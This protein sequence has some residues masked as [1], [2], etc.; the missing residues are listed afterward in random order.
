MK[1]S[2]KDRI[3]GSFAGLAVGDAMGMPFHE[4]ITD[5]IKT[6]CGGLAKTFFPILKE[7]FIHLDFKL[8]Q[9]TDDTTLT[10]V[11]AMAI[12]KYKG[13]VS[14]EH[15]VQEL[16]HWVKNN[17]SIWQL[18]NVY[19]P[20]TKAAFNHLDNNEFNTYEKRTRSWCYLGTSN[21]S[22]MRVS[23]AGWA[24]PGEW[25]KAVE[26]ACNIILPTHPTDVALS[27]AG[28]Q[29]AA[30]S[31]ALTQSA[32]VNSIIDAALTGASLGEKIGKKLARETS[33]RYPVPN[34]EIA[35]DLA[36]KAKDPYEAGRLIRRSIGSHFHASETLAT[37]IGIFYAAK[38]NPEAAIIA[39]VNNGGD[40]DTIA[41][42]VGALTGA[43]QGISAIPR[44]WVSTIETVNHLECEKLAVE[45]CSMVDDRE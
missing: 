10:V 20:S 21:G 36:E 33:Q 8:G 27:A 26:L 35:L 14:T 29:A 25:K 3:W 34:L 19:G 11:T 32:T 12:L 17:K 28:G 24:Y 1:I 18:G 31:Q 30:I 38:G 2:L 16:A 42:I 40:T 9:V 45:F 13:L 5:E 7:E 23:P 39:A 37:A 43:L 41:S 15:F 4:L 6:R 44:N 22:V